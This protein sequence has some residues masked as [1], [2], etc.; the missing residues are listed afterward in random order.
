MNVLKYLVVFI[1]CFFSVLL[2][3]AQETSISVREIL[4]EL[5][6]RH[7]VYFSYADKNL[8][9]LKVSPSLIKSYENLQEVLTNISDVT[10][11]EF[12]QL[13]ETQFIVRSDQARGIGCFILI[14]RQSQQP[15]EGALAYANDFAV[16]DKSGQVNIDL[17]KSN[18]C[19]IRHISYQTSVFELNGG[20]QCDTL[21]L[22]QQQ[23]L[24]PPL[25]V[26]NY[27][28]DGI[29]KAID[30]SIVLAV[31][32][33]RML[34]GMTEP[35][36]LQSL[37]FLPG[38]QSTN[39]SLA[40]LNIR[41]GTSD[42]N[43]LL[44]NDVR[45]YQ[46]G[47]FFGLISVFNPQI[48]DEAR[49]IKDGTSVRYGDAASGVI[50]L[51]SRE[52]IPDKIKV[53]TGVSMLNADA[54]ITLPIN[55]QSAITIG[56]RR[57]VGDLLKTPTYNSYFNRAFEFTEVN[58]NGSDVN[59]D[60]ANT[61]QQFTFFDAQAQYV[62]RFKDHR[63][64]L[65]IFGMMIGNDLS[66]T[67]HAMFNGANQSRK[68]SLSQQSQMGAFDLL[69]WWRPAINTRFIASYS[70]Y[71][72]RGNNSDI[73]QN[74]ELI[75]H[76]QIQDYQLKVETRWQLNDE[77][78]VLFGYQGN[79][80]GLLNVN[81]L[82]NPFIKSEV[83]RVLTTHV[84][85]GELY[86]RFAGFD[87]QMGTRN[88]YFFEKN[89]LLIEPRIRIY[90]H[91]TRMVGVEMTGEVKSQSLFHKV[92]LQTDFLGVE[93]RRWY[94][95][96]RARF[97]PVVSRQFTAGILFEENGF[98]IDAK[99]YIKDVQE[100]STYSQDFVNQ[101]RQVAENGS[102]HVKGIDVLINYR[103]SAWNAWTSYAYM[104]NYFHFP[105]L[106][107][108]SFLNNTSIPRNISSGFSFKNNHWD[109]SSGVNWHMGR[110]YTTVTADSV[111]NNLIVF[112]YPN[113][114]RLPAYFRW[115]ASAQYQWQWSTGWKAV[116]GVSIW[117]LT[118]RQNLINRY[119][120]LQDDFTL[121]RTD[122]PAL[123]LTINVVVRLHFE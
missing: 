86:T 60:V 55:D 104:D 34:P 56:S 18:V 64:R 16:S 87:L 28:S 79:N 99:G 93:K 42:Q 76:N 43:L 12:L 29:Y 77:T 119:F 80:V 7:G 95:E 11:L 10:G 4:I 66:F 17:S 61:D 15:V 116:L 67:E 2:V 65:K 54:S 40:D 57:S 70:Q 20:V 68:S 35:D 105:N 58:P 9:R 72:L 39:E 73:L 109:L 84:L 112:D 53:A 44:Y 96:D 25:Q 38:I 31:D 94:L 19:T 71:D 91:L 33:L 108:P 63:N 49:L 1:L 122:R 115:D 30:G 97:E 48:V 111:V 98:L 110:P 113:S 81:E 21:F 59:S 47:H 24:L 62:Y 118:N 101:F 83:K 5:E 26:Y 3:T 117:N 46:P 22:E 8:E 82:N 120:R 13:D 36:I 92:D 85:F 23:R 107:P 78:D 121:N 14:D 114:N 89:R 27:L 45:V 90:R 37:K 6:G 32:P 50:A 123:P 74:Q 100:I 52:A 41:G 103:W 88:V 69:K 51:T 106:V 102:Y 75:Q